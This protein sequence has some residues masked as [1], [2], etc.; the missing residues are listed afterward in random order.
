MIAAFICNCGSNSN[1]CAGPSL[2][3]SAWLPLAID[4]ARSEADLLR[5]T[6]ANEGC[7]GR[8]GGCVIDRCRC[9]LSHV[10]VATAAAVAAGVAR[11][12]G[13]V[14]EKGR[15]G[16]VDTTLVG[17]GLGAALGATAFGEGGGSGVADA[18]LDGLRGLLLL[19]AEEEEEEEEEEVDDR[20]DSVKV[21]S[22]GLSLL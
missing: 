11:V 18:G 14:A 6:S 22:A 21:M 3:V 1:A 12:G 9:S 4:A 15:R 10:I 2:P 13:G 8:G 7:A 20:R 16:F 19:L 17:D 5:A